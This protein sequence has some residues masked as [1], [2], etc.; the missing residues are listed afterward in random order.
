ME[1]AWAQRANTM[2]KSGILSTEKFYEL[3]MGDAASGSETQ[4]EMLVRH[5]HWFSIYAR[6]LSKR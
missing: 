1:A 4:L 6:R 5:G 3:A 2:L